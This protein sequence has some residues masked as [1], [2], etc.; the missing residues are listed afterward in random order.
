[1]E[2][3]IHINNHVVQS[4][5]LCFLDFIVGPLDRK[6]FALKERNTYKAPLFRPALH[7]NRGGHEQ[8]VHAQV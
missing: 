2:S 8:G 7:A 4:I 3:V 5:F 1:M 6:I